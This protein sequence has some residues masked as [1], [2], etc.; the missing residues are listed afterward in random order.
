MM[1]EIVTM[2]V[3]P[4]VQELRTGVFETCQHAETT[5]QAH[6]WSTYRSTAVASLLLTS[7][8]ER[9]EQGIL[10][11]FLNMC[12]RSVHVK[13]WRRTGKHI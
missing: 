9:K 3:I 2:C 13:N 7:V 5:L 1:C 6:Q 8:H 12:E 4:C 11:L 10:L